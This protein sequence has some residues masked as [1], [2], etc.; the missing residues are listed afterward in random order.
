[1]PY[2]HYGLD[3]EQIRAIGPLFGELHEKLYDPR[4]FL[5]FIREATKGSFSRSWL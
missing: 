5:T 3:F 4:S 2:W 1:M